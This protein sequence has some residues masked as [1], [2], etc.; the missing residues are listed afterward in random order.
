MASKVSSFFKSLVSMSDYVDLD[1]AGLSIRQNIYFRG[2]NVFILARNP[3]VFF[4]Q[5]VFG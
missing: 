2:P 5:C 3:C 1:G 4:R